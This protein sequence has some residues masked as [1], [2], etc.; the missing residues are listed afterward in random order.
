VNRSFVLVRAARES[1]RCWSHLAAIGT[2]SLLSLP[3][4]LLYPL[5]LKIA[6]DGVLSK[7]G[8]VPGFPLSLHMTPVLAAVVL[9][10]SIALLASLQGLASWWLSTYVGEKLVWDFRGKLLD[11]VQRLPLAFH[12]RY[13]PTDSVYRI[14]HDAPAIQYVVVQGILPLSTALL[15]LT[16]MIFVTLRI[17][18]ALALVA[19]AIT[20]VLFALSWSCGRKVRTRSREVKKLDSTALGVIQEVLASLRLVKAFNQEDREYERFVRHSG[21]RLQEQVNL[22]RLQAVYN[23]GISLTVAAGNAGVLYIGIGHVRAGAITIGSLLVVMAYITQ[24]YQPLQLLSTKLTDLEAW[25]TSFERALML[26]DQ[27]PE[28]AEAPGALRLQRAV[29]E[30]E[31]KDVTFRYPE[32]GRGLH[33][34]SFHVPAGSRVGIVGPSGAGKTT[35]LNLIMRF[36]DPSEGE[37]LI[38]G[39]NLRDYRIGDLRQQFAVVL[40][41]PV[42]FAASVAENIAYGKRDAQ[43]EEIIAAA[44]SAEAHDFIMRLPEQYETSAGEHGAQLSGGERQRISL[45][46][47]FLRD[48]PILILD[49]PTSAVDNE[50]QASILSAMDKL[51]RGRTAFIIA[52]RMETLAGCDI[53]L[54]LEAGRLVPQAVAREHSVAMAVGD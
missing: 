25:L 20:P 29:G 40:Q 16:G 52:H 36:Y 39:V 7:G 26:L 30:L 48:S 8:V 1:R 41:E 4:T 3:L 5:P 44:K 21:K 15:M 42:L 50:T 33:H 9:L 45:A 19:L 22:S 53:I 14:Q 12:D 38:D 10:L 37:V 51:M 47:A 35:L 49:E 18:H 34:V 24:M 27:T 13:G 17:D 6:V 46:R 54:S 28:I 43:D 32:G 11:H 2:L 31:F 23:M